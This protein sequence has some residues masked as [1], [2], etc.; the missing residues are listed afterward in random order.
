RFEAVVPSFVLFLFG[1]MLGTDRHR[2]GLS[3]IYLAAVLAFVVLADAGA[4]FTTGAWF[5]TRGAQGDGAVLRAAAAVGLVAVAAGVIVGPRL[6]GA[7]SPS[8]FGIGDR[9]G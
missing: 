8:V 9:P 2:I 4:R 3:A 5:G 7:D 6:P 1:A